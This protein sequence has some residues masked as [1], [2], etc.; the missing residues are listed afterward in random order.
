MQSL[1]DGTREETGYGL[2]EDSVDALSRLT[3]DELAECYR[4]ARVRL[5]NAQDE[6]ACAMAEFIAARAALRRTFEAIWPGLAEP[7]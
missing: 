5:L 1:I 2:D 4:C 3:L 7:H 6:K